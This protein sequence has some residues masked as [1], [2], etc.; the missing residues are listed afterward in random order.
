MHLKI[1]SVK[2]WQLSFIPRC[3]GRFTAVNSIQWHWVATGHPC[4]VR[5]VLRVYYQLFSPQKR[6]IN[7]QNCM[8]AIQYTKMV[9]TIVQLQHVSRN[10]KTCIFSSHM[11]LYKRNETWTYDTKEINNMTGENYHSRQLELHNK[12]V[13][14]PRRSISTI[15]AFLCDRMTKAQKAYLNHRNQVNHLCVSKLCHIWLKLWY[16]ACSTSSRY[17]NQ[18]WPLVNRFIKTKF[19][20]SDIVIKIWYFSCTQINLKRSL[21]KWRSIIV[22]SNVLIFHQNISTRKI[23]AFISLY[24]LRVVFMWMEQIRMMLLNHKH[25]A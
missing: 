4:L 9:I 25:K 19:Q 5:S 2:M 7:C 17:Q 13:C 15:C 23:S 14:F 22:D 20:C 16:V 18:R 6:W 3:L 1:P 10:T 11:L 12:Y 8:P 21:T 24:Y